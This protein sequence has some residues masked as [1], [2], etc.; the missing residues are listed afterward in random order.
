MQSFP[1]WL[2]KRMTFVSKPVVGLWKDFY[3][4]QNQRTGNGES[5][6]HTPRK[7]KLK[8]QRNGFPL[9]AFLQNIEIYLQTN[10]HPPWI[11]PGLW[12]NELPA[13]TLTGP[14]PSAL[15]ARKSDPP[16]QTLIQLPRSALQFA[17]LELQFLRCFRINSISGDSSLPQFTSFLLGHQV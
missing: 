16:P 8:R 11:S 17:W 7:T 4:K 6:A 14:P 3:L 15:L 1:N 9:R 12:T 13:W 2:D 10:E 5:H